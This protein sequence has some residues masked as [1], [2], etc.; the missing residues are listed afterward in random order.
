NGRYQ[1]GNDI[2]VDAAGDAYVVGETQSS[3]FPILN[4]LQGT[5]NGSSDAFIT[6]FGPNGEL[7]YST[8]FGGSS[9]D[10]ANAICLDARGAIYIG[11][12]TNSRDLPIK[13]AAQPSY[14]GNRLDG[15]IAKLTADGTSIV[16]ST[17]LGGD[18]D[19]IVTSIALDSQG[20]A[21]V[22]GSVSLDG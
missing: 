14:G 10:A 4:P 3:D 18:Q 6:K 7:L 5:L 17:Y 22:A 15:F 20:N 9:F 1:G 19:D 21:Y 16:Y 11:G 13:N 2:A 12:Q 8:C